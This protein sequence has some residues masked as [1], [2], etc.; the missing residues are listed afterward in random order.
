MEIEAEQIA[1]IRSVWERI[2]AETRR[3]LIYIEREIPRRESA[4]DVKFLR[5]TRALHFRPYRRF[6]KEVPA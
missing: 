6:L 1:E 2:P 4:N 5:E 3:I